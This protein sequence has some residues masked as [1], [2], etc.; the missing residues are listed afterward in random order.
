LGAAP[1]VVGSY[2]V[3]AHFTS[4]TPAASNADSGPVSFAITPRPLV[5]TASAQDKVYNGSTAATVTLADNRLAGDQLSVSHTSAMFASPNAGN[6]IVVTAGGIAVSG[7]S[8]GNYTFNPTVTTN[9]SITPRP[10]TVTANPET[11]DFGA[12][13]PALTYTMTAGSLVAG[14]SLTG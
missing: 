6:A 2:T 14:D 3:I 7:P 4:N 5:I 9:A 11:K 8:A 13:D 1:T 10:I 12:P